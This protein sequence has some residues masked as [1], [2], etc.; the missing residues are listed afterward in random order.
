MNNYLK[1]TI[2]TIAIGLAARSSEPSLDEQFLE[3]CVPMMQAEQEMPLDT[4][5]S[6]CDCFAEKFN[7]NA[8]AEEYELIIETFNGESGSEAESLLETNL[9]EKRYREIRDTLEVCN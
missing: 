6:V 3:F 9:G 4:S 2:L 5:K 7:E 1:L 8:S